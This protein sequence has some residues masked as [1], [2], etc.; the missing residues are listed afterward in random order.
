MFDMV[1]PIK[2]VFMEKSSRL[3]HDFVPEEAMLIAH[4]EQKNE[5]QDGITSK[6]CSIMHPFR[7]ATKQ[8]NALSYV[9]PLKEFST[10]S[11]VIFF[12]SLIAFSTQFLPSLRAIIASKSCTGVEF[13]TLSTS[14]VDSFLIESTV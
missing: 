8:F 14:M 3:T 7:S 1:Y 2:R 10:R 12:N 9:S 11:K 6:T 4:T 13:P 5:M